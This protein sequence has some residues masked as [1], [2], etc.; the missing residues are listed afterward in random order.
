M[1][2]TSTGPTRDVSS[3]ACGANDE[4]A[5]RGAAHFEPAPPDGRQ[6]RP[7]GDEGDVVA[8]AREPGAVI[9]AHAAGIREWQISWR[10]TLTWRLAP[11]RL[12]FANG[13][14][15]PLKCTGQSAAHRLAVSGGRNGGPSHH[16][17]RRCHRGDHVDRRP[18]RRRAARRQRRPRGPHRPQCTGL[19]GHRT[20]HDGR[21]RRD[22]RQPDPARRQRPRDGA[23][24]AAADHDDRREGRHG[25]SGIQRRASRLHRR[26]R[27]ARSHR[28]DRRGA[29]PRR[30]ERRIRRLGGR[31]SRSTLGPRARL[32]AR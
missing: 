16:V 24:E 26:R 2:T 12:L 9:P 30:S 17:R 25:P 15:C 19:Y 23:P 1:T 3:S 10:R 8:R 31:Q 7:A 14:A 5:E 21:G 29:R 11:T 32:A 27:R 18:H 20:G 13:A 6:M 22:S 28:P 4:P